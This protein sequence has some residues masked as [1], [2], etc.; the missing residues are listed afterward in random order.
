MQPS[1]RGLYLHCVQD[2]LLA[3]L[4]I[5]QAVTHAGLSQPTSQMSVTHKEAAVR[6][7]SAGGMLIMALT[8]E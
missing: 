8:A 7:Q 4:D 3:M 1:D 6:G 5:T 2:E